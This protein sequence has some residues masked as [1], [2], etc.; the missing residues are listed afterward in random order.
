MNI[1]FIQKISSLIGLKISYSLSL[2]DDV[3][4]IIIYGAYNLFQMVWSL[5]CVLILGIVFNV[6][7]Q[8]ILVC[9]SIAILRKYSGGVHAPS[10]N[11]CA[12]IGAV[13]SVGI[14]FISQL[15]LYLSIQNIFL[16]EV[17]VFLISYYFVYRLVPVDSEAKRIN[18]INTRKKFKKYSI[19]VLNL[20]AIVIMILDVCYIKYN[21]EYFF[22]LIRCISLGMLWQVFT[23]TS[24]AHKLMSCITNILNLQRS[25]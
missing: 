25:D 3:K 1:N 13:I 16:I 10:S 20:F 17:F 24:V 18:N 23:L 5:L 4:D 15:K 21:K 6:A 19:L 8:A 7:A 12:V 9:V 22:I 11:S 2:D 14:A